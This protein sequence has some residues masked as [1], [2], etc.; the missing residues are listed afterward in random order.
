MQCFTF[1]NF[2]SWFAEFRGLFLGGDR[3]EDG[4]LFPTLFK[5]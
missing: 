4:R 2:N 3:A 1:F 5:E